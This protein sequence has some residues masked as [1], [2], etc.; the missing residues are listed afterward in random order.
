MDKI[1]YEEIKDIKIMLDYIVRDCRQLARDMDTL[2][3]S[4]RPVMDKLPSEKEE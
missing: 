2:N 3:D 4:L 1:T